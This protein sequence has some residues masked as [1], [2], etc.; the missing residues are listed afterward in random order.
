MEQ[1]NLATELLHEVKASARRWFIL[2]MVELFIICVM[3]VL[4]IWYITLPV[5][6]YTMEQTS[7]NQSTNMIIGGNYNGE[8][9]SNL[10]ETGTQSS[11]R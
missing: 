4:F 6:E 1:M 7:D 8:A 3:V 2:A 10:Q 5:E 9:E 11:E